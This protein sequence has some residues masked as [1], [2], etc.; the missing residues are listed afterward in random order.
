MKKERCY[1]PPPL[2]NTV[3]FRLVVGSL[4]NE[5]RSMS[6]NSIISLII[7]LSLIAFAISSSIAIMVIC[8]I[9]MCAL[10][11]WQRQRKPNKHFQNLAI[12]NAHYTDTDFLNA[13]K[14]AELLS[15][16]RKQMPR[17]TRTI[18]LHPANTLFTDLGIAPVAFELDEMPIFCES[19]GLL[20]EIEDQNPLWER[21][22]TIGELDAFIASLKPID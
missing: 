2:R 9:A 7:F 1:A 12:M 19:L 4:A 20:Y 11:F 15:F 3:F 5:K 14:T 21:I 6:N 22:K 16:L 17:S 10:W 13:T 8:A 18:P